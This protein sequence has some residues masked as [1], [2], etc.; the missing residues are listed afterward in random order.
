MEYSSLVHDT[1]IEE[2]DLKMKDLELRFLGRVIPQPELSP[3]TQHSTL[4]RADQPP[5]GDPQ[6]HVLQGVRQVAAYSPTGL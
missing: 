1:T 5:Q 2:L 3:F 4:E 6:V